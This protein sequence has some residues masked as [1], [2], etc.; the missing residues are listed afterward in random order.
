MKADVPLKGYG[1]PDADRFWDLVQKA[2]SCWNWTGTTSDGYGK[3]WDRTTKQMKGAHRLS[4]EM[5]RGP[6]PDGLELDHLCRNRACVNPSHLE[7]VTQLENIRR[8]NVGKHWEEK[9]IAATL[10]RGAGGYA[11]RRREDDFNIVANCID[12]H[13]G[14]GGPDDNA[15]QANHLIPEI[16]GTLSDGAH[17]GGGQNGQDAYTGRIIPVLERR[18]GDG[19]AGCERSGQETD[20]AREES[21]YGGA[22]AARGFL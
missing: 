20:D 3:F 1:R 5:T 19:H 11:G 9:R 8:G 4:Y 16:V 17:Y 18:T 7:A 6:I 15:A 21:V 10:T 22:S 2:D 14:S 13:M 12:A